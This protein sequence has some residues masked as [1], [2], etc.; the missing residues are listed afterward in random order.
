MPTGKRAMICHQSLVDSIVAI[1]YE[2]WTVNIGVVFVYAFL[3]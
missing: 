3:A 1:F 2:D